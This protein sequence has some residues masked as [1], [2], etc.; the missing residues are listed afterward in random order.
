MI[1]TQEALIVKPVLLV[2]T[3]GN[4]EKSQENIDTDVRV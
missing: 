2:S 4:V 1:A 3:K